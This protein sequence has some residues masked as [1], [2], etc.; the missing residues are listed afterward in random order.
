MYKHLL[1]FTCFSLYLPNLCLCVFTETLSYAIFVFVSSWHLLYLP[2]C[3]CFA[4]KQSPCKQKPVTI[5]VLKTAWSSTCSN[6]F[7]WPQPPFW[8]QSLP[9]N[10]GALLFHAKES[11]LFSQAHLLYLE[12]GCWRLLE[13]ER[14]LPA[15][16]GIPKLL[17]VGAAWGYKCMTNAWG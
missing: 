3:L 14:L 1:L 15:V 6:S 4:L 8:R 10:S 9:A 12:K 13:H 7:P 17:V 2:C 11:Y 16:G 5:L